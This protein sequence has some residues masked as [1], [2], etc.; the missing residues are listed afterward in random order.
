MSSTSKV[1]ISALAGVAAGL[2]IGLLFAPEKGEETRKKIGEKYS[3]LTDTWKEKFNDLVRGVKDEYDAAKDKAG[4]GDK[5]PKGAPSMK[6]ESK[7][8]F[9]S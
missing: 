4:I 3:D 7:P 2:A 9:N 1:I 8:Q 5:A 6:N